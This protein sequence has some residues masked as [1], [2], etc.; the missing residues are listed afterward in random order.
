[1]ER[2]IVKRMNKTIVNNSIKYLYVKIN[3][4]IKKFIFTTLYT[5]LPQYPPRD[6]AVN[7]TL[8]LIHYRK[9]NIF[10]SFQTTD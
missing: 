4:R 8:K 3:E 10:D 9:S 5:T 7:L 1:M 6:I 2:K